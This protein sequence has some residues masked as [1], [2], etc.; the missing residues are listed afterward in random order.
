MKK[1]MKMAQNCFKVLSLFAISVDEGQSEPIAISTPWQMNKQWFNM[2]RAR[3]NQS[4]KHTMMDERRVNRMTARVN[5]YPPAQH[6]GWTMG[7][8][9]ELKQTKED[10]H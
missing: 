7:W 10:Q 3:V 5:Q 8:Q 6:D 9:D 1:K 4:H 2:M